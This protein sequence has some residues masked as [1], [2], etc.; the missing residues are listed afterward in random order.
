M[1]LISVPLVQAGHVPV[2][3][4]AVETVDPQVSLR[5]VEVYLAG[6]RRG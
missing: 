1:P 6:L 3:P 5:A 2:H 4:E